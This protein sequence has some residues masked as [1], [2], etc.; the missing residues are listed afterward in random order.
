[1]GINLLLIEGGGELAA[2]ALQS[3]VV[4]RLRL[5][6]APRLLGGNDAKGLIGGSCPPLLARALSVSSLSVKKIGPD[7]MLEGIL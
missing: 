4:D 6:I 3:G 7:L 1:M 5:Y 2:S